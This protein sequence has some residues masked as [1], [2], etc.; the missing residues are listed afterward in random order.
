MT[1]GKAFP[2]LIVKGLFLFPPKCFFGNLLGLR[3]LDFWLCFRILG[4][5]AVFSYMVLSLLI[6]L[7]L[8]AICCCSARSAF[9]LLYIL[10]HVFPANIF[11]NDFWV[12]ILHAF[13]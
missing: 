13:L 12:F 9:G 5:L 2:I 10:C 8:S 7:W 4:I 11:L 3:L 6:L 1:Y